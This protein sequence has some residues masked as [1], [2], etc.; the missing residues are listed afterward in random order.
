MPL[1]WK[2]VRNAG[3]LRIDATFRI[4]ASGPSDPRLDAAIARLTARVFR[5]AG[6]SAIHLKSAV[7]AL[8]VECRR[9][10]ADLPSLGED[11]SYQLD[12]ASDGARLTAPS[13]AAC[14]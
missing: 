5:Q 7:P 4:A 10:S 8:A 3:Q 12:I 14:R 11:E 2:I 6:L 9:S 13:T 1:P